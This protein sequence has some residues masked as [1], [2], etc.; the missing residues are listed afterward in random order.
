MRI[1]IPREIKN[2]ENRVGATPSG[3]ATLTADGHEVVV[4]TGAGLGSGFT[5]D[6]YRHAGASV[7]AVADVWR[8]DMVVKVKEPIESEYP[9]LGTQI[10]FTYFHLAAADPKLTDALLQGGTTAIAYE[11]VEDEAGRLPLLAPMSAVAGSMAP[12]MGAYHLARFNQGRGVLLTEI[13]GNS[14]GTVMVIGDGVV[15]R[16]AARVARA[17]GTPVLVFGRRPARA[18][19]IDRF[20]PGARYVESTPETIARHVT[21]ADLL[22]GATL[23]RG[24]RAAHL[25]T[26]TMVRTMQKGSVIVD[27][28][29][30]QGGCVETSRPT[31]HADPVFTMHGVIHYCVTN[32]PGAYPRTSTFALTAATLP[33][34]RRLAAAGMGAVTADP[35][36]LKGVNVQGGLIRCR[37]VAEALGRLEDYTSIKP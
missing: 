3:V 33:Y 5:D 17:M 30:D 9:R 6:E 36:F 20:A 2:N 35:G 23:A 16:H 12:L 34:V 32:M 26:E 27:V 11:T 7:A 18:P 28:S 31:S 22:V 14:Y 25:V 8:A 10:V 15:G 19:E 24:A 21:D 1:G 4:E 29:I 13:L 37:P